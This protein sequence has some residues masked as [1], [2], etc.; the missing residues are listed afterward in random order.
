MP[1]SSKVLLAR[2]SSKSLNP[3]LPPKRD[4]LISSWSTPL[5]TVASK[6][7]LSSLK[8]S[9]AFLNRL[10]PILSLSAPGAA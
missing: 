8:S 10:T 1:D 2:V 6:I 3:T 9:S 5:I 7:K 4:G